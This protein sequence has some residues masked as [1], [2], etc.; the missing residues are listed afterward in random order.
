MFFHVYAFVLKERLV[1]R[2]IQACDVSL[3]VAITVYHSGEQ[4][5][6]SEDDKTK[7]L[8]DPLYNDIGLAGAETQ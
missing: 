1:K 2:T 4:Y 3:F 7:S 6:A 5:E 8:Q